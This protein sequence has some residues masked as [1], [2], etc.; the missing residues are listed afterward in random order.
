M[1]E[2]IRS[3]DIVLIGF[4]ESVLKDARIPAWVAD[5]HMSALEGAIGVFGRRLLV[6][7]DWG[8]RARRVLVEAGLEAE[9]RHG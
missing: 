9:L 5:S 2:L 6:P 4:A 7:D 3:N 8:P 1:T